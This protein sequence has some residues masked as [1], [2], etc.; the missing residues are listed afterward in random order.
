MDYSHVWFL[1][2]SRD[3]QRP[4]CVGLCCTENLVV[5]RPKER[6]SVEK[7]CERSE[8]AQRPI[9]GA[10]GTRAVAEVSLLTRSAD[11]A[12]PLGATPILAALPRLQ[13][14]TLL[15]DMGQSSSNYQTPVV[16][17]L[18]LNPRI[19]APCPEFEPSKFLRAT[20]RSRP[21]FD[22]SERV[23][24]TRQSIVTILRLA[25]AGANHSPERPSIF[26]M[27]KAKTQLPYDEVR[28]CR[29]AELDSDRPPPSSGALSSPD[30]LEESRLK[31]FRHALLK[32]F[33]T[34]V[35]P[36]TFFQATFL[37]R[38]VCSQGKIQRYGSSQLE[39]PV[40]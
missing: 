28:L 16:P 4:P 12:R 35:P 30:L 36:C 8:R 26:F 6:K 31:T 5:K 14:T 17:I 27:V 22:P 21:R 24:P 2:P 7:I 13:F 19:L 10:K 23:L 3:R 20:V 9:L 18:A 33:S 40:S 1:A 39:N 15:V 11:G 29:R 25:T 34:D 37:A 38:R 32:V